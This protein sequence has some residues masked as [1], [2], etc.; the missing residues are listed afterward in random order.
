ME[1]ESIFGI[2]LS[3]HNE[4]GCNCKINWSDVEAQKVTFA[5]LKATQG[6][7]GQ[8][9]R[10]SNNWNL[11]AQTSILRGAYHFLSPFSSPEDQVKNFL[12]MMGP[13]QPKDLPPV[14]DIEWTDAANPDNDGWKNMSSDEIVQF[15]LK[16]LTAVEDATGRTPVIYTSRAWWK[17]R[18]TDANLSKFQRYPIW[19]AQ[20][21][22]DS[23]KGQDVP[24]NLPGRVDDLGNMAIHGVRRLH[25]GTK[26]GGGCERFQGKPGEISAD[27]R[28]CAPAA[29]DQQQ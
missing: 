9:T 23:T 12:K 7:T 10:F 22:P 18:I 20:Y 4:D 13:L 5:Y 15:A 28:S 29:H 3:H 17:D 8:D 2:D 1:E 6:A 27:I 26:G 25:A 11:L 24:K 16:W 14:M 21:V 19:L